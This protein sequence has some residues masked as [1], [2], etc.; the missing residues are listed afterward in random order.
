MELK[1]KKKSAF[2]IYNVLV[3]K[4]MF[5]LMAVK[6]RLVWSQY[7]FRCSINVKNKNKKNKVTEIECSKLLPFSCIIQK[8]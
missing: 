8:Y 2:D 4:L 7:L 3:I 5:H 1:S 6:I